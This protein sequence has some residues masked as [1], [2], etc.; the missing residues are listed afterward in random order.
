MQ[1]EMVDARSSALVLKKRK[2]ARLKKD[3]S[4][5]DRNAIQDF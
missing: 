4:Y 5:H 1:S 3:S 2:G